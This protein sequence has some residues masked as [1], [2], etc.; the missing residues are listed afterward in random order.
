MWKK[1]QL[2]AQ[3]NKQSLKKKREEVVCN[4]KVHASESAEKELIGC[5]HMI[6]H[7]TEE[8][9]DQRLRQWMKSQCNEAKRTLAALAVKRG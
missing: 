4:L 9:C 7:N 2:M 5:I 8:A 6:E 3:E 1:R